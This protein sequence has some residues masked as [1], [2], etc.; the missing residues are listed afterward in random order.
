LTGKSKFL[1][2]IRENAAGKTEK[3]AEFCRGFYL[4]TYRSVRRVV[5]RCF[6]LRSIFIGRIL[7]IGLIRLPGTLASRTSSAGKLP[8]APTTLLADE[9]LPVI[10]ST[11][12]LEGAR[13]LLSRWPVS[14]GVERRLVFAARGDGL[15]DQTADISKTKLETQ[16]EGAVKSLSRAPGAFR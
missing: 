12:R 14:I 10:H 6:E 7:F 16:F 15:S 4:I 11:G 2:S 8:A 9:N 3:P 1:E 5:R 13:L